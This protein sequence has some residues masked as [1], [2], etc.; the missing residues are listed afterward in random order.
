MPQDYEI[1]DGDCVNSVAY[2]HGFFWETLW[3]HGNNAELKSKRE[4]PNI[5]K[6]GDILHIPDLTLKQESC[7]TEKRHTFKL[8][9]VPAKLKLKLMRPKPEEEKPA[10]AEKGGGGGGMGGLGGLAGSVPGLPGSGGN[11]DSD[12]NLDDPIYEPPS[13]AEE[14]IANAPYIFEVDG[15]RVD[16][17]QTDGD[18]CV[19][20]PIIPNAREGRLIVHKGK[21]EEKIISLDLGAM[22]PVDEPP[23]IRK[24][25]RNLG[26]LCDGS[27]PLDADDAQVAVRRF[28]EKNS[29][30]V[31]GRV[32]DATKAK[33]KE[34]HGC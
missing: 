21:P 24:R 11:S 18:G 2:A 20:I 34:L 31:T 13:E 33:I 4:D 3:N 7:A 29:L 6:E 28:Q 15:V 17:G 10:K 22:D 27:G 19:K 9:G 26:Y 16:E 12:S 14:P 32:D 8:K 1:E 23:G 30:D 25:L 5:L